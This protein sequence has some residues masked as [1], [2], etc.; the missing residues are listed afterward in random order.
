MI[1]THADFAPAHGVRYWL[2]IQAVLAF[3]PYG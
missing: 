3:D 2:S 1:S